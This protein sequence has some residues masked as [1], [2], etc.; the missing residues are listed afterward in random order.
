[1]SDVTHILSDIEAGDPHA[2]K[3]R[4]PHV[5]DKL[6]RLAAAQMAREKPG[7]TRDAT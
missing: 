7:Q 2:A 6:R 4:L 5:E 1:M 3:A